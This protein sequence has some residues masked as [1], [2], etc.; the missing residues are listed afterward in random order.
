MAILWL[1][2]L[3]DGIYGLNQ[4]QRSKNAYLLEIFYWSVFRYAQGGI[5][6][7]YFLD[8]EVKRIRRS[9]TE[10]LKTC[11]SQGKYVRFRLVIFEG[12]KF[13]LKIKVLL[14]CVRGRSL[15]SIIISAN[16]SLFSPL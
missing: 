10:F 16:S 12:E 14:K 6:V 9:L 8:R 7:M 2:I 13:Y 3:I 11:F 15:G 4:E 1:L 5:N